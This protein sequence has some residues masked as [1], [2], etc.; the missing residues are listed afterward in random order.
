MDALTRVAR[1]IDGFNQSVGMSVAWLAI[2]M[3]CVQFFVVLLRYVFG[4]GSI[5]M[6]ESIL[7]MHGFLFCLGA[8]YTLLHGGHVR[9]DVFYREALPETKAKVDIFGVVVFLFPVCIA[10]LY[11]A[12]PYVQQ[13]WSIGEGST[14]T[15]GIPARYLLKTAIP[16]FCGLIMLQG[17]S[18]VIHSV[19]ILL[20][21]EA[22]PAEEQH[23]GL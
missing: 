12:L 2:L 18:M 4:Y 1:A 5:F 17:L 19:N 16:L 9:V 7:Y 21:R 22:P 14:E 15:S 13:S 3:V 20:G 6:Q 10:I 8:G 11:Y 23:E